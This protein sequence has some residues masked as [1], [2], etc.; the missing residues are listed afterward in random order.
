MNTWNR[1][2]LFLGLKNESKTIWIFYVSLRDII[3]MIFQL[4]KALLFPLKKPYNR[5]YIHTN[6]RYRIYVSVK[7][8]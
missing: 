3:H 1:L 6:C 8:F 5:H 2:F 4:Q 7:I